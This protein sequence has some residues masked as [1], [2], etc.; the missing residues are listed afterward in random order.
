MWDTRY[1]LW[2]YLKVE[3]LQ[4]LLRWRTMS[5]GQSR[6]EVYWGV[7]LTS[8]ERSESSINVHKP[9]GTSWAAQPSMWHPWHWSWSWIG[10]T[11]WMSCSYCWRTGMAWIGESS[12]P[13]HF[14]ASEWAGVYFLQF[15]Y[16]LFT[17][18][19]LS[20]SVTCHNDFTFFK[21]HFTPI[22]IHLYPCDSSGLAYHYP[23]LQLQNELEN[24][25]SLRNV[26][27]VSRQRSCCDM[28][29]QCL[30]CRIFGSPWTHWQERADVGSQYYTKL[31]LS[32]SDYH[33]VA[34]CA[35]CASGNVSA[36]KL[37]G[38]S[39]WLW[40][41]HAWYPRWL[42]SRPS[43][44]MKSVWASRLVFHDQN[45]SCLI[46]RLVISRANVCR[47]LNLARASLEIV[48]WGCWCSMMQRTI[49]FSLF[50]LVHFEFGAVLRCFGERAV[51]HHNQPNN[52]GES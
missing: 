39:F 18:F 12:D 20:C 36:L 23:Q 14:S 15:F 29:L 46:P 8:S 31:G 19:V 40:P 48:N 52:T 32:D 6:T 37:P 21:Y 9:P 5:V 27:I 34:A 42:E 26:S 49:C 11:A 38:K 16:I 4:R 24:P 44:D 2:L 1:C 43:Q 33:G 51:V 35:A 50:C 30:Q 28:D 13:L 41:V 3:I 45:L 10:P 22:Y 7:P 17:R 25:L 47:S